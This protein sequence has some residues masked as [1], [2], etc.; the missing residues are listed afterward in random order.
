MDDEEPMCRCGKRAP[1]DVSIHAAPPF[2]NARGYAGRRTELHLSAVACR[3]CAFDAA[4]VMLTFLE[5]K[6]PKK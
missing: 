1:L 6:T 5:G 2:E 3:D 4:K